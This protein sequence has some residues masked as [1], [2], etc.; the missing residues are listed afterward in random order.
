M[1]G[2]KNVTPAG[3]GDDQDPPR[4]F[5][6]V[7]VKTVYL[8]HQGGK[9]KRRLDR[10]TRAAI[11]AAAADQAERGGQLRISSNQIAFQVRRLASWS[12]SSTARSTPS[13]LVSTLPPTSPAPVALEPSTTPTATTTSTT[14]AS[15]APAHAST[16]PIPPPRF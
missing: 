3:G 14:P 10:A 13:D 9:K 2:T 7:R 4:S 12:H 15:T 5:R 16:P 11:A 6:Q 1:V 8:E